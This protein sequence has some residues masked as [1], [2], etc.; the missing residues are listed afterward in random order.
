MID[1]EQKNLILEVVSQIPRDQIF[2]ESFRRQYGEPHRGGRPDVYYH[3][4]RQEMDDTSM[5]TDEM[6]RLAF[7]EAIEFHNDPKPEHVPPSL[8]YLPDI[9]K[10]FWREVCGARWFFPQ[11]KL[12]IKGSWDR[13]S[14]EIYKISVEEVSQKRID[15][16][17]VFESKGSE[18]RPRVQ[19]EFEGFKFGFCASNEQNY[20]D[21]Y[22]VLSRFD[23]ERGIYVRRP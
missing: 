21:L 19:V 4:N 1:E 8:Y 13:T 18:Y 14:R 5:I 15:D 16:G 6:I 20:Y 17:G 10:Y 23:N 2:F 11:R 7:I 9:F 22:R 12:C 3:V